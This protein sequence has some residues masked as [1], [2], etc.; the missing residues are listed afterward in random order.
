MIIHIVSIA[1]SVYYMSKTKIVMLLVLNA[2]KI[3]LLEQKKHIN[4][5]NINASKTT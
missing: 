1:K 4:G 5:V 2:D 3:F